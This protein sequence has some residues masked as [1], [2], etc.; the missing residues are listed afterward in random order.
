MKSN[1]PILFTFIAIAFS[2][3]AQ[4]LPFL[5]ELTEGGSIEFVRGYPN[6]T[7]DF[8]HILLPEI[9]SETVD[10]LI[11]NANGEQ[12]RRFEDFVSSNELVINASDLSSGIYFVKIISQNSSY[13]YSFVKQ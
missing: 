13:V 10:V 4:Q 3:A 5:E 11:Y 6:P 7:L 8:T 2:T 12:K 9:K 1:F